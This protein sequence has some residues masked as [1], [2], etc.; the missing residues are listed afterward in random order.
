M[1]LSQFKIRISGP[2]LTFMVALL[3]VAVTSGCYDSKTG[4][5]E[6]GGAINFELPAFPETGSHAVV[7]FSEMHYSDSYRSQEIPRLL[8]PE[9]SVPVTG[10]EVKILNLDEL[11]G[12]NIPRKFETS[13]DDGNAQTVYSVNCQVCHGIKLDGAGPI[14]TLLSARND[15]S[16]AYDGAEPVNLNSDRVREL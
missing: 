6:F 12:L 3:F 4:K 8:P 16:L 11:A 2:L 15:G 1:F 9:G 7:V 14:T 13:Y 5:V 10:G